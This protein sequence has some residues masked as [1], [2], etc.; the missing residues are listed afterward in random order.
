MI[1]GESSKETKPT[2]EEVN[3]MQILR[4]SSSQGYC[5]EVLPDTQLS[6]VAGCIVD[7]SQLD[8]LVEKKYY[9][10]VAR[11]WDVATKHFD[12]GQIH[13]FLFRSDFLTKAEL[14]AN[15]NAVGNGRIPIFSVCSHLNAVRLN[16]KDILAIPMTKRPEPPQ[17]MRVTIHERHS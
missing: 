8:M 3:S 9:A 6:V 13:S 5:R 10:E 17:H 14:A 11:L 1:D 16:N 15:Q 12:A 4:S 7:L 2:N